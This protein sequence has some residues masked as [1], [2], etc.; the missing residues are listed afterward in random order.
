MWLC[1]EGRELVLK[2]GVLYSMDYTED[3]MKWLKDELC[4]FHFHKTGR[5][6]DSP[7]IRMKKHLNLRPNV[8]VLTNTTK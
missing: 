6:L 2:S 4:S 5:S 1:G 8:E 7:P 3:G